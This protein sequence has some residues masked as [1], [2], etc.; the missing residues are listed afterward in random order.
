MLFF[1]GTLRLAGYQA[2]YQPENGLAVALH[3]QVLAPMD[4]PYYFSAVLVAPDARVLP[5]AHW[6]PFEGAYPTT[7]W[8]Q[9][10]SDRD[11]VVD[12]I[13]LPLG[14]GPA[15]GNWWLSLRVFAMDH[16]QPLPPL[17]VSLPDGSSDTQ[18]GLG[19]LPFH[20]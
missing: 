2:R 1:G 9:A 11:T 7:C 4:R 18:A 19:P 20:N 3:W 12:Q 17:A 8:K 5:G 15:R 13:E 14:H 16:D 6:Q 10:Y